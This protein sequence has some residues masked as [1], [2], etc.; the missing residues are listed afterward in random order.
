MRKFELIKSLPYVK[1]GTVMTK[2]E[3]RRYFLTYGCELDLLEILIDSGCMELVNEEIKFEVGKW[4][5][6]K[7]EE[8]ALVCF[9]LIDNK[10][11]KDAKRK[12]NAVGY[13]FT[14]YGNWGDDIF[15]Y[16]FEWEEADEELV[17]RRLIEYAEKNYPEGTRF[18][19][20]CRGE[21]S[22]K[23]VIQK[24]VPKFGAKNR[25]FSTSFCFIYE[26]GKWADIVEKP[27]LEDSNGKFLYESDFEKGEVYWSNNSVYP[28]GHVWT[29]ESFN[30]NYTIINSG[31]IIA[32]ERNGYYYSNS[33]KINNQHWCNLRKATKEEKNWLRKCKQFGRFILFEEISNDNETWC[34]VINSNMLDTG[35]VVKVGVDNLE[36]VKPFESKLEAKEF[37]AK[38]SSLIYDADIYKLKVDFLGKEAGTVGDLNF[39]SRILI[40]NGYSE[41]YVNRINIFKKM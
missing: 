22:D 21:F 6:S 33:D 3:W 14:A 19:T 1:K 27:I 26:D 7:L 9:R 5:K 11:P 38:L 31:A 28:T 8:K 41:A 4:Y 20:L 39:W 12:T 2:E 24:N 34:V 15:F 35:D 29:F 17:K 40:P 32:Q 13:G 30:A 23:V 18:K 16:D 10:L 25:I 36:V 37:S